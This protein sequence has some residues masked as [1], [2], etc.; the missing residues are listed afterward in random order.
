[1]SI[2]GHLCSR[3]YDEHAWL[4]SEERSSLARI[5]VLWVKFR[6][7]WMFQSQCVRNS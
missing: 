5:S 4:I 6:S 1:L 2:V 3:T 7:F